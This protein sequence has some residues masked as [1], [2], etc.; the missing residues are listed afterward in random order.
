MLSNVIDFR[1]VDE[2]RIREP[3]N[4]FWKDGI[5]WAVGHPQELNDF[6][7]VIY[8]VNPGTMETVLHSREKIERVSTRICQT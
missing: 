5:L 8:S 6:G 1:F 7:D 2:T 4:L 3:R